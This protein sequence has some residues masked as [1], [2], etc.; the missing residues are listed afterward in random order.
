LLLFN[1]PGRVFGRWYGGRAEDSRAS[2]PQI[3]AIHHEC[4]LNTSIPEHGKHHRCRAWLFNLSTKSKA[5]RAST[6]LETANPTMVAAAVFVPAVK[7]SRHDIFLVK[8]FTPG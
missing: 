1:P 3:E 4:E 7:A 5:T 8:K 6:L 2:H